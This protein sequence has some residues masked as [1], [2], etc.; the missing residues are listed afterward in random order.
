MVYEDLLNAS[1]N[2]LLPG[3]TNTTGVFATPFIAA[4][5][6]VA[7]AGNLT[8][9][10]SFA[11]GGVA[12]VDWPRTIAAAS[13][14]NGDTTQTITVTGTDVYGQ[15][16]TELLTLTGQ[17][18]VKGNKAFATVTQI[19]ASAALAGN[20]T[21]D[22]N[23]VFGLSYK[24]RRGGFLYASRYTM[25]SG[26]ESVANAAQVNE[27]PIGPG[28][29]PANVGTFKQYDNTTP[30][31]NATQDVRGTYTVQTAPTGTGTNSGLVW[32]LIYVADNGPANSDGFGRSQ[33]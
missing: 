22:V 16:M 29:S 25:D 14:N 20:I 12:T 5:Q 33:V 23:N 26:V 21:V 19:A 18:T 1:G 4:S 2:P 32:T 17:T 13:A 10:G 28:G 24:C 31:T 3:N 9:N 11:T 30:A 6:A 27:F 15:V 7:G 8:I